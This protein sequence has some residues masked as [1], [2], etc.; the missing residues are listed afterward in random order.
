M[1]DRRLRIFI[2]P[3][4]FFLNGHF[5]SK[6]SVTCAFNNMKKLTFF[7]QYLKYYQKIR[8]FK[9]N[10]VPLYFTD[11]TTESSCK[12]KCKKKIGKLN[13]MIIYF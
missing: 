2:Y 11:G 9:E 12:V 6:V 1:T 7:Q 13:S 3:A 8:Q 5:S 4:S 10:F